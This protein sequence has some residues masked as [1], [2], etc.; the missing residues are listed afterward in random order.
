MYYNVGVEKMLFLLLLFVRFNGQHDP[1]A[2]RA[3][4][5]M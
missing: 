4:A 2:K 5:G 1:Y 3:K